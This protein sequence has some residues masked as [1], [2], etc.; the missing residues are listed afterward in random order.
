MRTDHKTTLLV[1]VP[2]AEKLVAPFRTKSDSSTANGIPPHVTILYPFKCPAS[3]DTETISTLEDLFAS[4]P[5]FEFQLAEICYFPRTLYL[6]PAPAD[7]FVRLTEAVCRA[8][9]DAL[10]YGGEFP[11]PTPHLTVAARRDNDQLRA[12]SHQ[13]NRTAIEQLPV[14]A[15]AEEI[16]L[17]DNRSGNWERRH[18]FRLAKPPCGDT[19][20]SAR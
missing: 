2:E 13:F 5:V 9:P 12:V 15:R 7:P 10:P 4:F 1:P 20:A 8:Y 16:W 3:V 18:S 11:E 14:S 6:A 19:R 17:M